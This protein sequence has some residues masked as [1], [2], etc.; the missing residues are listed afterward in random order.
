MGL[1]PRCPPL[2][3]RWL[4]LLTIVLLAGVK[5]AVAGWLQGGVA[6]AVNVGI[7][8]AV[9]VP[10]IARSARAIR[11]GRR[12]FG[13][14]LLLAAAVEVLGGFFIL[15]GAPVAFARMPIW[16]GP[17]SLAAC[18]VFA[19]ALAMIYVP[20]VTQEKRWAIR[21]AVLGAVFGALLAALG[22]GWLAIR[23]RQPIADM[24]LL[25]LALSVPAM[26]VGAF[27]GSLVGAG[28][29]AQV[30]W[31][32]QARIRRRGEQARQA[33]SGNARHPHVHGLELSDASVLAAAEPTRQQLLLLL[34]LAVRDRVQGLY[35]ESLGQ[36]CRLKR[37]VNGHL[38]EF[39]P[40]PVP[41]HRLGRE[42]ASLA[43]LT[44]HGPDG[45]RGGCL[46]LRLADSWLA[47][48]ARWQVTPGHACGSLQIPENASAA[49]QA[50]HVWREYQ[51]F[52]ADRWVCAPGVMTLQRA[53]AGTLEQVR[54]PAT[55][56]V[57]A[58]GSAAHPPEVGDRAVTIELLYEGY[59]SGQYGRPVTVGVEFDGQLVG[60]ANSQEGF[61][62][63]V[64]ASVGNH[65]FQI[66]FVSR[67]N[68]DK[69]FVVRV[70]DPGVYEV[71]LRWS[72]CFWDNFRLVADVSD[73]T[74]PGYVS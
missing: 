31:L 72:R 63:P 46:R 53:V 69:S 57:C 7:F 64:A 45:A 18:A 20:V 29:R 52:V 50:G 13:Q 8:A 15:V 66:K 9:T 10:C 70:L 12:R 28:W 35:W 14:P 11:Q 48:V 33:G 40:L 16:W 51:E 41:A 74:E 25:T 6:G 44:Q 42:I 17:V 71:R 36:V 39:G 58:N 23:Y 68:L 67:S 34:L 22:G 60:L 26:L 54:E 3:G 1:F 65:L 62:F 47:V 21:G 24:V 43:S 5:G 37:Q 27:A 38:T 73:R 56:G 19:V 4:L 49:E 2:L 30:R 55:G 59:R 32:R 61:R